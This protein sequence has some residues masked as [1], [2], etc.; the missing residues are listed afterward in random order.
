MV[1]KKWI[2]C[3]DLS[4]ARDADAH[5]ESRAVAETAEGKL[6]GNQQLLIE[7][8]AAAGGKVPVEDLR[9]A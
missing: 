1:R 8:L 7:T 6:N 2:V 5:D 3:E 9:D 4:D